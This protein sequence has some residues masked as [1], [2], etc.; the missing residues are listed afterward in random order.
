[1]LSKLG[2]LLGLCVLTFVIKWKISMSHALETWLVSFRITLHL[3]HQTPDTKLYK[4]HFK[5]ASC[6]MLK[7]YCCCASERFLPHTGVL[8]K[9]PSSARK[10]KQR[11]K[12]LGAKAVFT[13]DFCSF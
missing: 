7:G 6:K 11:Q 2:P 4:M 10:E 5:D 9:T 12:Y 3:T 13:S 8:G 1:M